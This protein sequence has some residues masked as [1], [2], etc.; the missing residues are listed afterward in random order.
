MTLT[1]QPGSPPAPG[2]C[3]G[4]R[5]PSSRSQEFWLSTGD[6]LRSP[7][8]PA[9]TLPWGSA[10]PAAGAGLVAAALSWSNPSR[11]RGPGEQERSS[12]HPPFSKASGSPEPGGEQHQLHLDGTGRGFPKGGE[13]SSP[14]RTGSPAASAKVLPLDP[15]DPQEPQPPLRSVSPSLPTEVRAEPQDKAACPHR[16]LPWTRGSRAPRPAPEEGPERG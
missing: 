8:G 11:P 3:G 6:P 10:A 5:V 16:A 2:P 9:R 15:N 4:H 13:L 12:S 7:R 1:L 14:C